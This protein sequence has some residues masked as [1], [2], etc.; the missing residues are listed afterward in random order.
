MTTS[1]RLRHLPRNCFK[2]F[3][4]LTMMNT[5]KSLE[6]YFCPKQIVNCKWDWFMNIS[7]FLCKLSF[8]SVLAFVSL[9]VLF[10]Y[11]V[12]GVGG[13]VWCIFCV[14]ICSVSRYLTVAES[15]VRKILFLYMRKFVSICGQIF[16]AISFFRRWICRR[17]LVAALR[18]I[19]S[20][21]AWCPDKLSFPPK[22]HLLIIFTYHRKWSHCSE[23]STYQ[24]YGFTVGKII[25][26][27]IKTY[28][29]VKAFYTWWIL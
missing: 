1:I 19:G 13:W 24:I 3:N 10:C 28:Q 11:C 23:L 17:G 5:W 12:G 2:A 6:E 25:W 21:L 8:L 27:G 7:I 29:T 9:Y 20:P 22:H 26:G 16:L 14:E 18:S 15:N 4:S